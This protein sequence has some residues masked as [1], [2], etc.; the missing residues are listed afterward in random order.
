MKTNTMLLMLCMLIGSVYA[1]ENPAKPKASPPDSTQTTTQD[2]IN[3][4]INYSSPSLKGREIGVEVAEVG[5]IWRTGANE[6]TTVEVDKDILINEHALPAGKYSLYSIPGEQTTTI[7][8]NKTWDQW[9]TE[10]NQSE[11]A[12][13]FEVDNES[14]T[15]S[16]ERFKIVADS[17]GRIHLAWG[18]YALS[19]HVKAA[20]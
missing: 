9:G 1:Q 6:A 4:K 7:I 8:F 12:L 3:I 18:Q 5:K 15:E 16:Q 19:L 10:Y 13:R 14:L 20:S 17:S 2:G 11:D